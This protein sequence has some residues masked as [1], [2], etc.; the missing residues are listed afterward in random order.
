MSPKNKKVDLTVYKA[1]DHFDAV[2]QVLKPDVVCSEL[3]VNAG[4]NGSGTPFN[5]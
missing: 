1:K 2:E 5:Y 3:R 4:G